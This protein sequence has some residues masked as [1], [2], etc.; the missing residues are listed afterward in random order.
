MAIQ[1]RD[2]VEVSAV[3]RFAPV[4]AALVGMAVVAIG[5]V[6][7]ADRNAATNLLGSIYEAMGNTQGAADLERGV[8]DQVR[9]SSC[10][11]WWRWW[12][13]SAGSGCCT[14]A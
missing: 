9:P 4:L 6:I 8:G 12:S 10:W 11:A 14:S 5:V 1:S 2:Q 13:A 7:L 3:R